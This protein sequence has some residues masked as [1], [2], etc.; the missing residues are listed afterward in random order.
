LSFLKFNAIVYN[1]SKNTS[2]FV[3]FIFAY[4]LHGRFPSPSSPLTNRY[5]NQ[6]LPHMMCMD[7]KAIPLVFGKKNIM[8]RVITTTQP[9]WNKMAPNYKWHN[10]VKNVCDST[11]TIMKCTTTAMLCPM[12]PIFMGKVS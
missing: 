2:T 10:T 12:L 4:K 11:K 3:S 9:T 6:C 5:Q 7:S 8:K 1:V